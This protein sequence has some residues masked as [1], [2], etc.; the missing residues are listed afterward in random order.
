ME[1][2]GG[3]VRGR[4][5]S[6]QAPV[7]ET[8]PPPNTRPHRTRQLRPAGK[9]TRRTRAP[10]PQGGKG[11]SRLDL[12]LVKRGGGGALA[13]GPRAALSQ[14]HS[15]ANTASPAPKGPAVPREASG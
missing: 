15:T 1:E 14:Q 13:L 4:R 6:R 3:E 10:P 2:H 11:P 8:G 7:P 9:G 5:G 12:E